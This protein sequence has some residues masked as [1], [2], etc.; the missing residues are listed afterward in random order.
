MIAKGV[1]GGEG[2]SARWGLADKDFINRMD[3]QQGP[4][5]QHRKLFSIV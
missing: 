5:V 4:T 3:K 2:W 1:G